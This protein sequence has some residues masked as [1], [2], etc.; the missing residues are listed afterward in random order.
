MNVIVHHNSMELLVLVINL[1][2]VWEGVIN[3]YIWAGPEEGSCFQFVTHGGDPDLR[4]GEERSGEGE[5]KQG[6]NRKWKKKITKRRKG[7][8]GAKEEQN[9]KIKWGGT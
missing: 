3:G 4:R 5:E 7:G 2:W 9:I 1:I 8:H 6:G